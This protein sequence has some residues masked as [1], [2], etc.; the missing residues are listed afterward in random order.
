[1]SRSFNYQP[2]NDYEVK[3]LIVTNKEIYDTLVRLLGVRDTTLKLLQQ[4]KKDIEE[5]Y[6]KSRWAKIGGTV[7][8]ITGAGT[9]IVGLVL[10]PFTFGTSLT[11]TIAGGI[12]AATGGTTITGAEIGYYAVSKQKINAANEAY[13]V[14]KEMMNELNELGEKYQGLL[15]ALAERHDMT[16]TKVLE[17]ANVGR[18]IGF[19][20]Y[21]SYKLVDGVADA[22]KA[23]KTAVVAVRAGTRTLWSGLSTTLRVVSVG[24]VVLDAVFIPVDV[25]VLTKAA[26]DVHQYNSKGV[27]NS[28][29]AQEIQE[30]I[31]RLEEHRDKLIAEKDKYL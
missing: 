5:S 7:G 19:G 6:N 16:T 31:E 4:L 12:L 22:A 20:M 9:S 8:T 30:M 13:K 10:L 29:R 3:E 23:T 24:A 15:Q 1:M 18:A 14:D 2:L 17:I 28:T 11:L 26:Y 21:R 27:S 25:A